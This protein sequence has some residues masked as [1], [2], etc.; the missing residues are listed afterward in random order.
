MAGRGRADAIAD[1]AGDPTEDG[2]GAVDQYIDDA[3]AAA[4]R[5]ALDLARPGLEVL[6]LLLLG[7][8]GLLDLLCRDLGWLLAELGD[9]LDGDIAG[10]GDG[11][12]LLRSRRRRRRPHHRH[13]RRPTPPPAWPPP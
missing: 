8:L 9:L 12:D 1:R 13:R 11:R 6:R 3:A 7:G 5:L 2:H 10:L 4:L